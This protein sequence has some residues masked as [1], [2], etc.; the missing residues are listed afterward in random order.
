MKKLFFTGLITLLPFTLTLLIVIFIINLLTN[1][2]Q[3]SVA[4]ILNH[5]D[6]LDKPF[7][8]FSAAD[9]LYFSSKLLILAI[10]LAFIIFIG[11]LGKMVITKTFFSFSDYIIHHIPIINKVYKS[12]QEL[13]NTL[14]RSKNSSFSQAAL[15][16]FPHSKAY[17]MAFISSKQTPESHTENVLVFVPGTPNPTGGLLLSFKYEEIIFL[18]MKVEDALKFTISC[19]IMNAEFR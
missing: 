5:Y 3:G 12:V 18:D 14:F 7:L 8:I 9:I 15:V 13:V 11:F 6:L 16:P 4:A 2:F 10:L 1:P 17:S 19:G